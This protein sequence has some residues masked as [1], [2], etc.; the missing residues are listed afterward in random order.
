VVIVDLEDAVAP[1]AK[2]AARMLAAAF[3]AQ[4]TQAGWGSA[5]GCGSTRSTARCGART[6]PR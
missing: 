2:Q 4:R 5:A 1:P 6:S 3:L